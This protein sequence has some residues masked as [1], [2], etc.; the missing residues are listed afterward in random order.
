MDG[1]IKYLKNAIFLFLGVI[2]MLGL[3]L[4]TLIQGVLTHLAGDTFFAVFHYFIA[5]AA[6]IIAI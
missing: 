5:A 4:S 3:G 2:I 1:R 6:A